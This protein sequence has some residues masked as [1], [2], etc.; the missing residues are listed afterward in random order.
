MIE[1]PKILS[2]S[3]LVALIELLA[4]QSDFIVSKFGR[5]YEIEWF[6]GTD[7]FKV[8][9]KLL[10]TAISK[11]LEKIWEELTSK[12]QKKVDDIFRNLTRFK[13]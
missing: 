1:L 6:N 12:D 10:A 9:D 2:D 7:V 4:K 13:K 8:K 11:L 5:S 3:Q